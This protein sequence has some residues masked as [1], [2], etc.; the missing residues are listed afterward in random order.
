ML[1]ESLPRL[2]GASAMSGGVV[3]AGGGTALQKALGVEDTVEAMYD[4]LARAV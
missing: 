4:F 2:G 3:Y 1:L